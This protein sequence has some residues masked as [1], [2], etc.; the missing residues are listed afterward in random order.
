VSGGSGWGANWE[1]QNTDTSVPGYNV[2][3]S[4]L[5][6][7]TLRTSGNKAIGGDS[8]QT[9]G[10]TFNTASNGPFASY[11]T[12]G[13]IGASG[14]T[15]YLSAL[16]RKDAANDEEVSLT[17]HNNASA[18]C[19]NCSGP[20]VSVGYFGTSSNNN[21]TRYWSLKIGSTVYRS[22]V[23][24]TA[25]QAALLVVKLDF[26]STSTASLYVN[27]SS[28]GGSAPSSASASGTSTSSLAFKSLAFY[29]GNNTNQ[30]AVDE[31]RVGDTF[32]VVTP[33]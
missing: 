10:R 18:W 9:A 1:V 26:A 30:G 16:L 28:L 14:K 19:T 27:P 21:G 15:L 8:Y 13:S 31:I 25:N 7:A 12:N 33:Q 24:I 23:A 29:G 20:L 6:F 2:Q 22:N 3:A 4:S 32:G 17:L 11:L 5:A